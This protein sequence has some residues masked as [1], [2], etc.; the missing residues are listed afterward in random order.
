MEISNIQA[1][2]M[3]YKQKKLTQ[4]PTSDVYK[5]TVQTDY[6]NLTQARVTKEGDSPSKKMAV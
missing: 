2:E 3:N 4:I 6:V 5:D 1:K